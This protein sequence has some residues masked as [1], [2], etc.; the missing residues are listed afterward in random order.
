MSITTEITDMIFSLKE[1]MKNSTY[2]QLMDKLKDIN[3]KEKKTTIVKFELFWIFNR[4]GSGSGSGSG[5]GSGSGS[6]RL[7][8]KSVISF[9]N[10][11]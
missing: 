11:P 4:S 10:K 5:I 3:I 1:D 7:L 2:I 9:V 6:E 8:Y